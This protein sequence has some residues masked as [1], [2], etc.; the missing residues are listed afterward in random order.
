MDARQNAVL[1]E[2]VIKLSSWLSG[3]RQCTDDGVQCRF[4]LIRRVENERILS[5]APRASIVES[6]EG[7]TI[8]GITMSQKQ[9]KQSGIRVCLSCQ[10]FRRRWSRVTTLTAP[11]LSAACAHHCEIEFR[12]RDLE[13]E[14]FVIRDRLIDILELLRVEVCHTPMPL[15]ADSRDGSAL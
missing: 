3:L 9:R 4:R 2:V 5:S 10:R 7:N 6:P 15:D 1:D 11:E 13:L 14:R 8:Y 12:N